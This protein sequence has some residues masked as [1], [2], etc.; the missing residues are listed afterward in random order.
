MFDH[1][2]ERRRRELE[3]R[4]DRIER[5]LR[6]EQEQVSALEAAVAQVA[7]DLATAQTTLQTELDQL[8]IAN[9]GVDLSKLTSAVGALDP[10]VQALAALKPT[11]EPTS[12]IVTIT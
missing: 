3:R 6:S 5:T 2:H 12:D 4:V 1:D 8:V 7:T 11:P 10:A 9:P